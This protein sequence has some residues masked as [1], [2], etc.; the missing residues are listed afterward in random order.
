[1]LLMR[2]YYSKFYKSQG[3]FWNIESGLHLF[4]SG[5][6]GP[7]CPNCKMDIAYP[8]AAF[9]TE[10]HEEYGNVEIFH[11]G[12]QGSVS[13]ST[14]MRKF[15]LPIPLNKMKQ[16]VV[17]DYTLKQRAKINVES[18]DELPS[19]V[20]IRDDDNKYFIAA[21]IGEKDG[22]R[23]GVVYFGEKTKEQS[24]KDYS[25]IFIDL[26]DEQVRFDK[27][28]KPPKNVIAKMKVEFPD[29]THEENYKKSK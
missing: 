29:S 10:P 16:K 24:K 3:F 8:P 25:Q 14:C 20:K 21:K 19:Q 11:E 12:Y 13:C 2:T 22:K 23:V 9:H 28:N 17:L 6:E 18:L 27:S 15:K 5:V 1:M 26:D 7:F 4:E